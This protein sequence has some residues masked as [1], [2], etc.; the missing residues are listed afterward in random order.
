MAS[1]RSLDKGSIGI[2]T[3]CPSLSYAGQKHFLR[4]AFFRIAVKNNVRSDRFSLVKHY[5]AGTLF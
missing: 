1:K 2:N 4:R 5:G 3:R